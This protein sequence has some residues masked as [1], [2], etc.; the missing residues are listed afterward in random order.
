MLQSLRQSVPQQLDRIHF[1]GVHG[2]KL[3]KYSVIVPKVRIKPRCLLEMVDQRIVQ[4]EEIQVNDEVFDES[5][6]WIRTSPAIE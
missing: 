6:Q 2:Q 4:H 1:W 3:E 5:G